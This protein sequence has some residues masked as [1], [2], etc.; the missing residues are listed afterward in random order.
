[1]TLFSC[2][3]SRKVKI[4][5][6]S[7]GPPAG[8]SIHWL[9]HGFIKEA[10]SMG[11]SEDSNIYEMEDLRSTTHG[12]IRTKGKNTICPRDGKMGAA[13][14]D[15]LKGEDNVGPA[16]L[17]LSYG[18]GYS[19]GDITDTLLD[20]CQSNELD[21]K[22]TYVWICCL[23]NNQHRVAAS[24]KG[25]RDSESTFE[26]F[27]NTFH[28]R[29][30]EIGHI[31]ALMCPWDKPIYIT[32]IWCIFELY[33]ASQT[34]DCKLTIAMPPREKARM[35]NV[36]R[37][38]A[39]VE[40]LYKNLAATKVENA[41]ATEELDRVRILQMVR[42][43]PGYNGLNMKVNLLL[44]D[45][46]KQ[47]L[48]D[49]L[50]DYTREHNDLTKDTKYANLCNDIAK[51]MRDQGDL[52]EASRLNTDAIA[53]FEAVEEEGNLSN[54]DQ[55][56][57]ADTYNNLGLL[58]KS[59]GQYEKAKDEFNKA[60]T[61]GKTV[62]SEHDYD[63]AQTY[64]NIGLVLD[65]LKE[66]DKALEAYE[67]AKQLVEK[68]LGKDHPHVAGAISNIAYLLEK[69]GRRDEAIEKMKEV[70][71]LDEKNSGLDHPDTAN[72][73]NI[74]G[75]ILSQ[76]GDFDEALVQYN[77]ALV[78]REK[79]F[80][81]NSTMAAITYHNIGT[82]LY[83]LGKYTEALEQL[84]HAYNVYANGVGADHPECKVTASYIEMVNKKLGITAQ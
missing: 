25:K 42:N 20:Y 17:M 3:F 53:I 13:Y 43:G 66:Y 5:A 83:D 55:R 22:R 44:R 39:G 67:E 78:V 6:E 58:Y 45:W 26:E 9:K 56:A 21:P 65:D 31:V 8:V 70:I 72:S 28:S 52:D 36:L 79:V 33:V 71:E 11:R 10:I 41:N 7:E 48:L 12:V 64:N 47:G 76:K 38:P 51:F 32:R 24:I 63:A 40:N 18:W 59:Q 60:L 14:V 23:C 82:V 61:I 35:V 1:M 34:P 16:N 27:Q 80:G 37:Q 49:A 73:Y 69:M 4:S 50:K 29:V 68:S 74:L 75:V 84:Q 15:C 19:I 57:L 81:K 46:V 2:C 30:V 54:T 62:W 77:K